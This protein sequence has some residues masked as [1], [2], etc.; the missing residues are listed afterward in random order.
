MPG[1]EIGR[2]EQSD[3]SS[4]WFTLFLV[5]AAAVLAKA[6]QPAPSPASSSGDPKPSTSDSQNND[7]IFGVIPNYPTIENPA[8]CAADDEAEVQ[9]CGG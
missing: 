6:Q 4:G 5:L 1:P 7:R 8:H 3:A 9:A 2:R